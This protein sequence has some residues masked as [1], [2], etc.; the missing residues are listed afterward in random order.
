[1]AEHNLPA[2]LSVWETRIAQFW[3]TADAAEGDALLTKMGSLRAQQPSH[4][5]NVTYEMASV[6]DFIG[7]ET[8]AIPLYREALANG[9]TEPRRSQAIIQLASSLRLCGHLNEAIDVLHTQNVDKDVV[10]EAAA[11]FLALTLWESGN[12]EEALRVSLA[13]LAQGLPLYRN[14]VTRYAREL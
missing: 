3:K 8:A 5:P 1:M 6:H 9:L 14:A 12:Q 13:A 11:A 10:G 2:A 4:S 7:S